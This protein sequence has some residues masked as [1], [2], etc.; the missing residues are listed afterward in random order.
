MLRATNRLAEAEPL[1]HRA[2][3]IVE[4]SSGAEHP[5]V[6]TRL[7]GLA[8]L[9]KSTN[10]LAEAEP[11]YRRA[12]AIDEQSYGAEHPKV[13]IRINNLATLLQA[14]NRLAEAEPLMRRALEIVVII[15]KAIGREHPYERTIKRNY[16]EILKKL[17]LGEDQIKQR[18]AAIGQVESPLKSILPEVKRLLGPAKPVAEVLTA[19]DEQ[20]K[21]ESKPAVYFLPADEPIAPHL[22]QLLKPD[23]D[24]LSTMGYAAYRKDADATAIALYEAAAKLNGDQQ[25]GEQWAL[26]NRMNRAAAL[27]SLGGL[28]Q[29][30]DDLTQIVSDMQQAVE[31]PAAVL[32][33]CYYHLAFCEWRLGN[34]EAAR[35][36]A[37]QSIEVYERVPKDSPVPP[38]I[39]QQPRRMLTDLESGKEPPR[40]KDVEVEAELAKARASFAASQRLANLPLDK[41]VS[42]HMDQLLGPSKLAADTDKT[43]AAQI[44]EVLGPS[45]LAVEPDKTIAEQLDAVLGRARPVEEVLKA[46]DERYRAEGRPEIWFLPLDEPISPHLDELLGPV[47]STEVDASG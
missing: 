27:R 12:L 38:P 37:A 15:G 20:N 42:P 19:L 33:K 46:L 28:E 2:L 4:Q 39:L 25:D 32:G 9:L 6:A 31:T 10:R 17:K 36:A 22:E 16:A 47:A 14:T 35:N 29:A 23:R 45:K 43:I 41:R 13:A 34:T 18:V 8:L 26:Q 44:D 21:K 11:L 7:N 30:R 1:Y 3:A 40:R 5:E 24:V